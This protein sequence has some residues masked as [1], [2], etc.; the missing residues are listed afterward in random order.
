[1]FFLNKIS[2]GFFVIYTNLWNF[3]MRDRKSCK[4]ELISSSSINCQNENG[5]F[6]II[7]RKK[8]ILTKRVNM[9]YTKIFICMR[10]KREKPTSKSCV[11]V[12]PYLKNNFILLYFSRFYSHTL[13]IYATTGV[14][15]YNIW[16]L[17]NISFPRV[18]IELTTCHLHSQSFLRPTLNWLMIFLI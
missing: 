14:S 2:F 4:K 11:T 5:Y 18:E 15:I 9:L 16:L 1:M 12:E 17:L 13:C 10:F 7:T 3:Y 6:C 8:Y